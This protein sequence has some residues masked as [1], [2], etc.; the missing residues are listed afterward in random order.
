M[1]IPRS[2]GSPIR[3]GF[4]KSDN[5]EACWGALQCKQE[6]EGHIDW[7]LQKR[8]YDPYAD[9]FPRIAYEAS[10]GGKQAPTFKLDR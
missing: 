1:P 10:W 2:H 8:E 4:D 5:P 6:V 9:F 7:L 3:P